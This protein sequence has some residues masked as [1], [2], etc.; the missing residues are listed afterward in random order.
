[1]R[2]SHVL[3][4]CATLAA[5]RT[6]FWAPIDP[7]RA[8]YSIRASINADGSTLT[9]SETI[10]FRTSTSRKIAR[11]ALQF[12]GTDL[13]VDRAE[14]VNGVK[15]VALFELAEAG[16]PEQATELKIEWSIKGAPIKE[17]ENEATWGGYPRLYWG[18]GT[19]DDYEV[20]LDAPAGLTADVTGRF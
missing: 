14:R 1:M 18:F 4:V 16:A 13:R 15:S 8:E 17:G 3:L 12:N 6:P 5:A 7:P 19:L 20:R 2:A 11:I 10:R 9:G